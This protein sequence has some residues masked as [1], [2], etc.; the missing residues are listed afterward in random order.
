M[1]MNE[2]GFILNCWHAVGLG[3]WNFIFKILN[4]VEILGKE[5]IPGPEERSVLILS[6]H[7][8]AIDPFLIAITS[9]RYFS[10]VRWR[11]P[12]KEELFNYPVI[13]NILWSWGA[14]PVRRG[15]GDHEAMSQMTRMLE[16]S[17]VV[18]FP[19]GT[20]SKDGTLLKGRAGVGKIIWEGRPAKILPVLVEGTNRILPKGRIL[21]SIGK[22][23]RIYYGRPI[24]LSPYYSTEP[25]IEVTQRMVDEIISVLHDMQKEVDFKYEK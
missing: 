5:N 4:R 8:S 24:D 2:P 1:N 21:P 13:R 16:D 14:F 20:R 22:K 18:L 25:A 3:F 11:A 10:K 12:A 17:V 19:E 7:I 6:N 9:L 23:T 15:K